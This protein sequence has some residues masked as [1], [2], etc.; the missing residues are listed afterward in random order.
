[1]MAKGM[2]L[3]L[4]AAGVEEKEQLDYLVQLGCDKVQGY[5]FSEALP[6]EQISSLLSSRSAKESDLYLL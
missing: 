4:A 5:F 2:K 1:M 3:N 6:E